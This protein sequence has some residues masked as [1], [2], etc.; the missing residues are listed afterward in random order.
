MLIGISLFGVAIAQ[1]SAGLMM[2]GLRSDISGPEDLEGRNVA[3]VAGTTSTAVAIRLGARLREVD[4]IGSAHRLLE[5]GEV[6]AILFDAAPLMRY[7]VEDG[8]NTVTIV[9]PLIERQ[10][11]GIAFPAGSELRESVN[12]ALLELEESGRLE[13]IRAKWFGSSS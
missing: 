11:Y 1:L 12:R 3:T 13:R 5:A 2:E 4:T 6:D 7:V 8:N 9:G 10:A